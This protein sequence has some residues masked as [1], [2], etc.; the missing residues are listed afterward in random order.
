V[1]R[2]KRHGHLSEVVHRQSNLLGQL[3]ATTSAM[4][5]GIEAEQRHAQHH[6]M[7][8]GLAAPAFQLGEQQTA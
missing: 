1:L 6:E 7:Y 8:Q 3:D 2:L 4:D 5:V